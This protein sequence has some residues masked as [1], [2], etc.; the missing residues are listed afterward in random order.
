[1]NYQETL[2]YLYN[3]LPVFHLSGATAYKPGLENTLK[4]MDCL[5]NPHQ[6]FRTIHIAGTNGKGSVS[7]YLSAILQEAGYQVGLYTSPHLVDFGERIKING[8]MIEKQYV[9][10]FIAQHEQAIE[11]VQPSFFE[12]TMAMSFCYFADKQVDIAIIETGLGGRLDS[13]NIIQPE[14]S[15]ITNIGFDHTEFLG[16]TYT[17]I[18]TE[19]AGIIKE[20]TPVVIGE[21]NAETKAVFLSIAQN[22]HAAIFFADEELAQKVNFLRFAQ[23]NMQFEYQNKVYTS[24]LSALYQLK[25]L[26]TVLSACEILNAQRAIQIPETAIQ[27]GIENIVALTGLRGRW[28]ILQ[29]TPTIIADTAHNVAGITALVQQ[30]NTMTYNT[31][32]I[33]IGMVNDKDVD[34]VLQL[35]PTHARYYFTH[36]QTNRAL[37]ATQLQEIATQHHLTGTAHSTIKAALNQALSNAGTDDLILITGSNF[38]VGE[39]LGQIKV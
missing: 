22:K 16:N 5:H 28:E 23:G 26:R 7:H 34:G 38:V 9:V 6:E 15:I 3:R 17:S 39:A 8:E 2:E 12:L 4:L 18:A 29:E 21:T 31:L 10:D 32:H 20:N 11:D 1:M 35:L 19:K 36:A 37:P 33:V 13:T 25:N 14:L 24:G 30:L 27:L